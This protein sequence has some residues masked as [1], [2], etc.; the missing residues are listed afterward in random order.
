[1]PGTTSSSASISNFEV[2]LVPLGIVKIN[3]PSTS[4]PEY[5]GLSNFTNT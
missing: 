3:S 4:K 1:M 5:N 2:Y